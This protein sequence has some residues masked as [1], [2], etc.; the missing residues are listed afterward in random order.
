MTA[1]NMPTAAQHSHEI[2]R[3]PLTLPRLWDFKRLSDYKIISIEGRVFRVHKFIVFQGCPR[4]EAL[5]G[6]ECDEGY[7]EDDL[8][9]RQEG[10]LRANERRVV[11][12][13]VLHYQYGI[14]FSYTLDGPYSAVGDIIDFFKAAEKFQLPGLAA[15]IEVAVCNQLRDYDPLKCFDFGAELFYHKSKDIVPQSIIDLTLKLTAAN[16]N[17]IKASEGQSRKLGWILAVLEA[18]EKFAAGESTT[19][20]TE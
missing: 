3:Q 4:F 9:P 11:L 15:E 2:L 8:P 17:T 5:D 14:Q 1:P 12:S 10:E 20:A 16:L 19:V 13:E 7:V 18:V 6:E